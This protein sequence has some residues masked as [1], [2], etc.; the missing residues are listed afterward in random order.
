MFSTGAVR[1][2]F[3][4][5]RV[6]INPTRNE[7]KQSELDLVVAATSNSKVGKAYHILMLKVDIMRTEV[8]ERAYLFY[9]YVQKSWSHQYS[10]V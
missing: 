5:G 7:L 2:G 3:T 1:V 8:L 4:D 10:S 9:V 6:I